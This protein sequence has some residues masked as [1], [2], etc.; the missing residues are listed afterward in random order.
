MA[1]D[2]RI[3]AIMFGGNSQQDDHVAANV[4]DACALIDKAALDQPDLIALPEVFNALGLRDQPLT[5]T[6]EPV[7]GPTV[8]AIAAKAKDLGTY[9]VCPIFEKKDGKIFNSSILI[10]RSGAVVGAYHK[11]F[12]TISE[13]EEGITPGTEVFVAQTDFG[14]VGFAICFDLNFRPV[15]EA[16]AREGAELV[17]FSSMY[18][19]GLSAQIWAYDFGCYLVSS[20]PSEMSHFC[21]P[22]GRVLGDLW[23]YQPVI[24]RTINLDFVVLH[25]DANE[26]QWDAIRAKYGKQVELDIYGPE[27]VFML[28]SKHPDRSAEQIVAEFGLEPRSAYFKRA[29][30]V[31]DEALKGP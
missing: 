25:I 20:T 31:R 28:T 27:G 30:R 29:A 8:T 6:A 10:D 7:D 19:G 14:K 18:R 24:T 11:M 5:S 1:R 15:G 13:I 22:M 21:N 23:H 2:A 3:S 4:A 17:V 9:I 26:R 16:N 12:P